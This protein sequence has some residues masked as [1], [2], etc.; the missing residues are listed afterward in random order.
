[1]HR[2]KKKPQQKLPQQK[3]NLSRQFFTAK[4]GRPTSLRLFR[5][6]SFC[7]GGPAAAALGRARGLCRAITKC[8]VVFSKCLVVFSKCFVV[9]SK[10]WIVFPKCFVVLSKCFV[11]LSKCLVVFPKCLVVFS[12]CWIVFPVGPTACREG[13]L[14][15]FL[16][17]H[18][19]VHI[20]AILF[21]GFCCKLYIVLLKCLRYREL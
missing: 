12:K 4:K 1:M 8:F 6:L 16:R 3:L 11:V 13:C 20:Y 2:P 18:A 9:F 21:L 5:S 19:C 7:K 15:R 10:C 14:S 17:V